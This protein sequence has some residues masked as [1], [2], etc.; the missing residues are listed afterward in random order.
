MPP[1]RM[2]DPEAG[3]TP[4]PQVDDLCEVP[5]PAFET[6]LKDGV[7]LGFLNLSMVCGRIPTVGMYRL[8]S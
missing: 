4:V 7:S 5:G 1:G 3:P 6:V 2:R 8:S